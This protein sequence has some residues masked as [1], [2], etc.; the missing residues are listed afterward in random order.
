MQ[1][2]A[3][4]P[5][6]LAVD[7]QEGPRDRLT[8]LLRLILSIPILI[9]LGMLGGGGY[10]A[11][12][13]GVVF[14]ATA[15]MLVARHKYPRWWFDW[16]LNLIRFANRIFAYLFLLRDEYPSTD[17]EQH[18]HVELPDP[19][20]GAAV[21]RWMPLVKWFLAIPHFVVLFFLGVAAAVVTFVAW[22]AI[23]VTGRHPRPL[24]DFVVGV[25]RWGLR[26][27]AYAFALVVDDYPPFR[28]HD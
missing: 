11:T 23:L 4:Y 8:V 22:V 9:V 7:Y 13:A 28:L 6:H 17:E 12:G 26:V 21:N 27:E 10:A 18:V 15:L 19:Q 3:G 2:A 1:A 24:Y 20:G 14:V 5:V 25:M 16:N